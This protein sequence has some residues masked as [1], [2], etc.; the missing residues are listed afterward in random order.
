M[1][2]VAV[3]RPRQYHL[4]R[5]EE[6]PDGHY[7]IV[8]HADCGV[9]EPAALYLREQADWQNARTGTLADMAYVICGWCNF[10]QDQGRCW[11]EGTEVLFHTWLTKAGARG[12]ISRARLARRAGVIFKW[13]RFL[14]QRDIGGSQLRLFS[15][16]ISSN[17]T[18]IEE[19]SG[20]PRYK[21]IRG[22]K[23]KRGRRRVPSEHEAQQVLQQ[24]AEHSNPFLAE[25]NW[26][27]GCIAQRTGL[28]ALGLSRL[29]IPLIEKALENEGALPGGLKVD[30][31]FHDKKEMASIRFHLLQMIQRGRQDVF[32]ELVEKRGKHRFV[33]FPIELVLTLLDHVWGERALLLK[34]KSWRPQDGALW[35]SERRERSLSLGA[36]K[37]VV[38]HKGFKASGINGSVHSLR[39][40]YLTTLAAKLL[41]EEKRIWGDDVDTRGV[42]LRLAEIAGH[43]DPASLRPY[44][45]L[46]QIRG[47]LIASRDRSS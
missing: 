10:L 19:L 41:I 17:P 23:L 20:K 7:P 43:D 25:R 18:S 3:W 45:D 22:P 40:T 33:P 26:L 13:T 42:L 21:A 16:S 39:A 36:I 46:A 11:D 12:G 44:L 9:F 5:G 34:R 6:R 15:A 47:R 24:L 4:V 30:M 14:A 2:K 29:T 38:L 32:I 37:D 28:R 8:V 1:I 35:I 27:I 31:A